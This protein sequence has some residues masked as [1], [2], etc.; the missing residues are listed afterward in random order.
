MA[1]KPGF[2][3][4]AALGVTLA[5]APVRLYRA[6]VSPLLGPRCRYQPTCSAYMLEALARHGVLR[7]G[8]LGLARLL[9]C[10]PWARCANHDPVPERFDWRGLFR[11]KRGTNP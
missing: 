8:V 7:G 10:H 5:Q 3:A 1:K 4:G 11:Y 6:A 2:R 9:R